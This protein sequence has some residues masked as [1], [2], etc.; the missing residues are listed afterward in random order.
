MRIWDERSYVPKLGL[1]SE[2]GYPARPE[3]IRWPGSQA[4][5]IRRVGEPPP[6][7]RSFAQVVREGKMAWRRVI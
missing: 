7:S 5:H 6:L 1:A 3:E 2:S 4:R